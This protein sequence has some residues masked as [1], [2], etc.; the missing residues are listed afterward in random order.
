MRKMAELQTKV[1]EADKDRQVEIAMN[2][3]NNLTQE[4]MK[5]ADMTVDEVKLRQEQQ[6]TAIRLNNEVQ[7]RLGG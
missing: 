1:S 2:T 3:E 5:A 4:R 6:E 7:Q